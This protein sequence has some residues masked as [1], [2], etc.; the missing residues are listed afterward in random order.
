MRQP[1]SSPASRFR[2]RFN[3]PDVV[4]SIL[5][6]LDE[7]A[8]VRQADTARGADVSRAPPSPARARRRIFCK[9]RPPVVTI[10]APRTGASLPDAAELLVEARS[11]TGRPITL[12]E[13]RVNGRPVPDATVEPP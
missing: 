11:P 1:T 3:R 12:V 2:D 4:R 6:T 5:A 8:A 7:A 10:L 13:V 9:E